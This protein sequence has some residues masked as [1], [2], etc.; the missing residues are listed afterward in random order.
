MENNK[1]FKLSGIGEV[2]GKPQRLSRIRARVDFS[3]PEEEKILTLT[4]PINERG[5]V[6]L[7]EN[8]NSQATI[9]DAK[10]E[11]NQGEN[12]QN[13]NIDGFQVGKIRWD[14]HCLKRRC[15][16]QAYF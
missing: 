3:L 11:T 5:E 6:V 4:L 9:V 10:L 8:I 12:L 14:R 1:I 2:D 15:N 13:L 16:S 7:P